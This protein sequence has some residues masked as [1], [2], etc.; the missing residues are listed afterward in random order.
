MSIK[1]ASQTEEE[2][3]DESQKL[4]LDGGVTGEFIKNRLNENR[5]AKIVITAKNSGTGLGKSTLAYLIANWVDDDFDA[6]EQ[7]FIDVGDYIDAYEA[8]E[9]GTALVLDEIEAGADS[10]RAMSHENV[11]LSRAWAALRYKNVITIATLP[12]TTML[13]KRL[14]ELSDLWINVLAKGIAQPYFVWFND[15]TNEMKTIATKHPVTGQTEVLLWDK[16]DDEGFRY[17]ESLKDTDVFGSRDKKY[18]WD[19]VQKKM[20]ESKREKRNELIRDLYENT[21]L[22]QRQIGNFESIDLKQQQISQI[23]NEK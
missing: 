5:D 12:T 23:V 9:P 8:A 11:N 16:I 14:M 19:K 21:S 22:S 13:D 3:S 20:E 17:M 6:E 2:K 18:D 15:F 10:R 4:Q 1:E 7:V